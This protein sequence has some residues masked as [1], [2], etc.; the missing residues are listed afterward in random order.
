MD[1]AHMHM[2]IVNR[3][4]WA[5]A[6]YTRC[7]SALERAGMLPGQPNDPG[8]AG[9]LRHRQGGVQLPRGALPGLTRPWPAE[10]VPAL[11]HRAGTRAPRERRSRDARPG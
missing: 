4:E 10:M 7:R 2:E 8:E 11:P 5:D 3:R 1:A 9:K 6:T